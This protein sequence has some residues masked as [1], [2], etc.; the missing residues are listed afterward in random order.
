MTSAQPFNWDFMFDPPAQQEVTSAY[1]WHEA[2]EHEDPRQWAKRGCLLCEEEVETLTLRVE[3][4]CRRSDLEDA[5]YWQKKT[6][7]P[8]IKN[9]AP[10]KV[11]AVWM[12]Q[13]GTKFRFLP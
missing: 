9:L 7:R 6:D 3:I 1:K 11:L 12:M 2:G 4:D 13:P 10:K 5:L 8:E